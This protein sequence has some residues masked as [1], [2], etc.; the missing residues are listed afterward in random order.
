MRLKS[1]PYYRRCPDCGSELRESL[2]TKLLVC[3]GKCVKLYNKDHVEEAWLGSDE[4]KRI[5]EESEK[6]TKEWKARKKAAAERHEAKYK[7]LLDR[8][9]C[10]IKWRLSSRPPGL[11]WLDGHAG[12][13]VA[14][15][16]NRRGAIPAIF[17]DDSVNKLRR[18]HVVRVPSDEAQRIIFGDDDE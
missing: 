13:Y 5:Q 3:M 14:C 6:R 1:K 11:L 9:I 17:V 8:P 16:H 10:G 18:V 4:F 12:L 2:E 7:E 15:G